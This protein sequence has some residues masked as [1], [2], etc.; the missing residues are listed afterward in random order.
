MGSL[1]RLTKSY[2]T[3]DSQITRAQWAPAK[4]DNP[5]L[6]EGDYRFLLQKLESVEAV[7][8]ALPRDSEGYGLIHNDL[9]PTTFMSIREKLRSLILTT[10]Y[11]AGLLWTSVSPLPKR[12]GWDN[13][14]AIG[15]R[16]MTSPRCFYMSS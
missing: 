15:H 10:A 11:T 6:Q 7:L 8:T 4:I 12:H 5:Y 3:D 1:H 16:V 14:T 9:H 2:R 13:V